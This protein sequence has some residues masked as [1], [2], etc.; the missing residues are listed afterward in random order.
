[1]VSSTT[2]TLLYQ[3]KKRQHL[4]YGHEIYEKPKTTQLQKGIIPQTQN[5]RSPA[6]NMKPESA[7][8]SKMARSAFLHLLRTQS[9]RHLSSG[10]LFASLS[11]PLLSVLVVKLRS[12]DP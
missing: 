5:P 7:F 10:C 8:L 4:R 2:S 12:S 1:M 9:K 11:R 3:K 6:A